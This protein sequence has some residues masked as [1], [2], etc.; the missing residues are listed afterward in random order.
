MSGKSGT[1]RGRVSWEKIWNWTQKFSSIL[2]VA[3]IAIFGFW[4]GHFF[5]PGEEGGE[6]VEQVVEETDTGPALVE[7]SSEKLAAADL[8]SERIEP[9]AFQS[10]RAVP[11]VLGFDP[12]NTVAIRAA[13]D[14]R[15]VRL[16]VQP[17]ESVQA[18][19]PL[20]V[21]SGTE[22]GV[23]RNEIARAEHRIE[24]LEKEYQWTL[25]THRNIQEL[26]AL[27]NQSPTPE[28]IEEKFHDRNLGDHRNE[29]LTAYSAYLL[30]EQKKERL[31]TLLQKGAISGKE[32]DSREAEFEM[33][34]ARLQSIRE[35]MQF[36][37]AQ[38]L[39]QA[40]I[41]LTNEKMNLEVSRKSLAMLIGENG[42][43]ATDLKTAEFEVLAPR[44][45]QV[46]DLQAVESARFE[47]GEKIATIAD[48]STLWVE[49]Q[50]SQDTLMSVNATAGETIGVHVPSLPD[51]ELRATV[52][53]LGTS[54]S[55]DTLSIPLVATL[56]NSNLRLRA[57]M[58]VRVEVPCSTAREALAV[59]VG[60]IQRIEMQPHVFIRLSP[61]TFELRRVVLGAESGEQ[62]EV[63]SGLEPG[64]DVVTHAAFFLK[65]EMLLSAEEE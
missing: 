45:G 57:G 16:L 17:N 35:E 63:I 53:Y 18:G 37:I 64:E 56:D 43:P 27:L 3:A 61:T 7:V 34:R 28:E 26:L 60:A 4:G 46:V 2:T 32:A 62:V 1:L 22:V 20:L 29:L 42:K 19:Q 23:A 54:V 39:R 6:D 59:P 25:D 48:L 51:E 9:T 58:A 30:A 11:G 12:T 33:A 40:E 44:Q 13:S 65:S 31:E 24:L 49:A 10:T 50:I 14:C 8:R 55:P 36:Q 38:G 41:E 21:M 47:A 52:R 5:L 15:V